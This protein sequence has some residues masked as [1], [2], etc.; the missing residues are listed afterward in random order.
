MDKKFVPTNKIISDHLLYSNFEETLNQL[1]DRPVQQDY[2]VKLEKEK[3]EHHD[4][5]IKEICEKLNLKQ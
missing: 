5:N 3:Q 1:C 2:F 4:K